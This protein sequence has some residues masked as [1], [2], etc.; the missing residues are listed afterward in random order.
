[1]SSRL[2]FAAVLLLVAPAYITAIQ[3]WRALQGFELQAVAIFGLGYAVIS[4]I[5]ALHIF[6]RRR[7][8]W[9]AGIGLASVLSLIY[10]YLLFI[11]ALAIAQGRAHWKWGAVYYSIFYV[12]VGVSSVGALILLSS[13][14]ARAELPET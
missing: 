12:S 3:T 7:W 13:R 5:L 9:V 1:M 4:L 6:R 10:L 8:A 14:K 2:S 11:V